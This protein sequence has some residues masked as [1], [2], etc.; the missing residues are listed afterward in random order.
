MVMIQF[1]A[2]D[3]SNAHHQAAIVGLMDE[4]AGG[5]SGGGQG[6][7]VETKENLIKELA[8]RPTCH[9]LLGMDEGTPVG[10]AICF[11]AFST[12]AC[13]P[14]LN[15]HDFAIS[16]AYQGRGLARELLLKIEEVARGLGCCKA[17][18]EVLEGNAVAKHVYEKF[19]F[20]GYELD[21]AMGQ[22]FFMEMKL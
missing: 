14:I 10:V 16:P 19:G 6:L 2:P 13:R 7:P 5:I 12:F 15:I 4:Y 9:V 22:A 8:V 17:T 3:F 1:F 21:P 18:L 20:A 11:E